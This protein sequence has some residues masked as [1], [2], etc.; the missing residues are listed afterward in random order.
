MHYS[1]DN[2]EDLISLVSQPSR[3]L[4]GEINAVIKD[5]SRVNLKSVLPFLMCMR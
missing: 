2:V 5:L 1:G 4:G 3:Y